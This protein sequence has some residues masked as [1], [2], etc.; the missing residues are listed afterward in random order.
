M[1][2][3]IIIP[4]TELQE[5]QYKRA[6]ISYLQSLCCHI[7]TALD[8][9]LM[10][11]GVLRPMQMCKGELLLKPGDKAS[12]AYYLISGMAKLYY[13]DYRGEPII[14]YIWEAGSILV[15]FKKFRERLP[16]ERY[17]IELME[18]AD[19]V[20]VTNLDM[21]GIYQTHATAYELTEKILCLKTDRRNLHTEILQMTD[22]KRRYHVFKQCFPG[23]YSEGKWRLS[24]KEICSFIGLT[25][26]TLADAR[27]LYPDS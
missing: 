2:R 14:A 21:D 16:N 23:L 6:T 27:K 22:K 10:Q 3:R 7:P 20:G 19:L 8:Q 12:K 25:E 5:L 4:L 17:Y 18:D 15:M 26:N 24:N 9:A 11:T 1:K 13:Y